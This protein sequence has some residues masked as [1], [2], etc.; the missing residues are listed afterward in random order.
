MFQMFHSENGKNNENDKENKKSKKS[1]KR[2]W[3]ILFNGERFGPYL[4]SELK[5]DSRFNPETF[6]WKLGYLEW[7]KARFVPEL[8]ELFKDQSESRDIHDPLTHFDED[9][10]QE[11][12]IDADLQE[13]QVVLTLQQDPYQLIVLILLLLI[14]FLYTYYLL[15]EQF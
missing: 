8:E 11:K 14:V 15:R 10:D 5:N 9:S 13:G 6:V 1:E 7:I 3:W 4:P 12:K 2:E